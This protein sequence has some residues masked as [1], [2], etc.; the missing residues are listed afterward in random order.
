M[1]TRF[2]GLT[3]A[4]AAVA[5]AG[6]CGL[7]GTEPT[8]PSRTSGRITLGDKSS[9]TQSVTCTQVEQ[10]L[11]IRAVAS[12]GNARAQLELGAAKPVVRT[13]SLENIQGLNGIAGSGNGKAEASANGSSAYKITGTA[14][15]SDPAHPGQTQN[16]PFSIEAPC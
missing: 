14:V 5:I 3:T 10:L 16:L 7:V 15:V 6:G 12:P 13:V 1:H 11:T 4:F 2:F 8:E 9:P